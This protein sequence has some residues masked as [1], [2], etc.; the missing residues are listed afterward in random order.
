MKKKIF[1]L[2]TG[3]TLS[4]KLSE[5]GL[6]PGMG[7]EELL[8]DI[9]WVAKGYSLDFEDIY[10]LDSANMMPEDW[11]NMA[12]K[13]KEVYDDYHGIVIIHGTDTMAYTASM[14]TYM[15][16]NIPIPVVLTGSQLSIAHPVADAMENCRLAIH[17]AAS[18][19]PGVFVAFNRKI[20]LGCRASKVR[21]RSFDAFESINY[22]DIAR[23]DSYGMQVKK[24][25]IPPIYGKF[26]VSAQ[27]SDQVFLLK[28]VPGLQP[29][30][31][32]TLYQMGY[33]GIVIEAFG[34][35]GIP[36][37]ERD[38]TKGISQI[39]EKGVTVLV[40][41][42]CHY[43]G[44]DLSV[45]ETGKEALKSGVIQ[46]GDMTTEAAVTKLMWVL[47]Q[48]KDQEEIRQYFQEDRRQ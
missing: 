29:E 5:Q 1:I 8:Q 17:M 13:I 44:S 10:S 36:F 2:N 6:S 24:E 45:Y 47:G 9:E 14:L 15:L 43:E 26:Q 25:Y 39:I 34:M 46:I 11:K 20:I 7:K 3:G 38:L 35:G 22:P 16:Q 32:E 41:T 28:L 23:L 30:I 31:F 21:T 4:S 48:T 12:L 42:Q 27:Y 40:G 37:R 19:Y 18:G 33:R